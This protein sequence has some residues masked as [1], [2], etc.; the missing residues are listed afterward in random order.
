MQQQ[1]LMSLSYSFRPTAE[2]AHAHK[3]LLIISYLF[4]ATTTTIVVRL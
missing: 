3:K 2:Y 1:T 4:P